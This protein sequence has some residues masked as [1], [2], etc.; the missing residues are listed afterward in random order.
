[1]F[2][3]PQ[4]REYPFWSMLGLYSSLENQQPLPLWCWSLRVGLSRC[5]WRLYMN[6]GEHTCPLHSMLWCCSRRRSACPRTHP[7]N[8]GKSLWH[9]RRNQTLELLM[10]A[11]GWWR[12]FERLMC[13]KNSFV[14][15]AAL[16]RLMRADMVQSNM[17]NKMQ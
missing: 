16:L 8:P 4:R 6:R 10:P 17:T 11:F 5:H 9:S 12:L 14:L 13:L 3:P 2:H 7:S 1:M 15:M